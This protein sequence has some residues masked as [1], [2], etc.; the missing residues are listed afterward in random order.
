MSEV[1]TLTVVA[2]WPRWKPTMPPLRGN[3]SSGA[4]LPWPNGTDGAPHRAQRTDP[5]WFQVVGV[6]H[7]PT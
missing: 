6:L 4:K 3:D 5:L 7:H 1:L 2:Q